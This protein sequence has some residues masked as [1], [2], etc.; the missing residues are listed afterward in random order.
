M[1]LKTILRIA[2]LGVLTGVSMAW[3]QLS[4]TYPSTG[5][6]LGK[7]NSIKFLI[8]NATSQARVVVTA[9]SD[10][11]PANSFST[12]G[13]F[14]PDGDKKILGTLNLNFD[15]TSATDGTYTVTVQYYTSGTLRETKTIGSIRIDSKDPKFRNVT[16][17]AS[18]YVN[19][20]VTIRGEIEDAN[21]DQWRV[22]VNDKDIT[23]NTGTT[24]T[25][26]VDWNTANIE[27]DGSVSISIKADDKAK[28]SAT[29][30]INVTLDRL[31]PSSQIK[32][33]SGTSYRPTAIIPIV[34]DI[35]DQYS[36]SVIVGGV[37]ISL[38]TMDGQ[39]ISRPARKSASASGNAL[40]WIGRIKYTRDLPKQFKLVVKAM[41]RAGNR[42]VDQEV[43]VT[44]ST[45]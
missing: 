45:R 33:P 23:N 9:K 36:D 22:K 20:L 3:A 41:D 4:V 34:V 1:R 42:A 16:P 21:L 11:N 18:A 17:R 15:E 40:R 12:D 24:A 43:V 29:R 28:N 44:I 13:F 19:Q 5:D 37:D 31:P 38:R 8:E 7:S 10:T 2:C 30:T 32:S 25:F 27:Q 14:D 6:I 26:S 35:T 39:F